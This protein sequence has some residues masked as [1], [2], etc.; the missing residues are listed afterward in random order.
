MNNSEQSQ[1]INTLEN[2]SYTNS[3]YSMKIETNNIK[4]N[5]S[6]KKFPTMKSNSK[7]KISLNK[8]SSVAKETKIN[9]TTAG[10]LNNS[11]LPIN[12]KIK[13]IPIPSHRNLIKIPSNGLDTITAQPQQNK[14]FKTEA[15]LESIGPNTERI[16]KDDQIIQTTTAKLLKN[17]IFKLNEELLDYKLTNSKLKND[18]NILQEKIK[19]LKQVVN[20]KNSESE[21]IKSK[22][23]DIAEE[24]KKEIEKMKKSSSDYIHLKESFNKQNLYVKSTLSI[25]IDLMEFLISARNFNNLVQRQST[26]NP[27][28]I[29]ASYSIDIYDSY[30]NE[31][32][33]K[34][35]EIDQIQGLL[36]TK[37]NII[38]KNIGIDLDK[39]MERVKNWSVKYNINEMNLSNLKM[40]KFNE[41]NES[42]E[43]FRKLNSGDLFDLSTSNHIIGQSPKFNCND[44]SLNNDK[45]NEN[46]Y[47]EYVLRSNFSLKKIDD[48]NHVL[49][50]SFLKDLK[51]SN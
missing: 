37:L 27:E 51:Q 35:I 44:T 5:N 6:L 23:N 16:L 46:K 39:E 30:N 4:K 8:S 25:L 18:I 12:T 42:S 43:S 20:I 2:L 38:K 15:S 34:G 13:E 40:S 21:L 11:I 31:E 1:Q 22:Y 29:S 47:A 10:S 28:N 3:T 36:L 26:N 33:R 9:L 41:N 14:Y 24:Y 48:D 17:D 32:E 50:D 19:T 7:T 45:L 49:N